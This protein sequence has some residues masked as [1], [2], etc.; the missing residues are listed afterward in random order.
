M[1][2]SGSS[3][4]S[5]RDGHDGFTFWANGERRWSRTSASSARIAPSNGSLGSPFGSDRFFCVVLFIF[6]EGSSVVSYRQVWTLSAVPTWHCTADENV[7]EGSAL[8]L[9]WFS[10][11]SLYAMLTTSATL[12]PMTILEPVYKNHISMLTVSISAPLS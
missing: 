7:Q 6:T 4:T 2:M 11:S 8:P 5:R 3:I 9:S 10:G 1:K 12:R